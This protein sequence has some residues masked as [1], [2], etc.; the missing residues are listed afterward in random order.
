MQQSNHATIFLLLLTLLSCSRPEPEAAFY[1]WKST[2]E[3][4]ETERQALDTLGA[5]RLYV[6]FFD[7]DVEGGAA[8]P[9]APVRFPEGLPEGLEIVPCV[10]ITNRTFQVGHNPEALADQAWDY[11]QQVNRRYGLAPAEY[12]FD[13]DWSPSNR[14]AYFAFLERIN[15]LKGG[16][17]ASATIRLHQYRYPDQTGVPPVDKG[18]LMYYNMGDIEGV[19]ES[20]SLL[21]NEKGFAYLAETTYPLPLDVALPIFSWALAYRLG[22]L[23]FIINLPGQEA[24]DK[25]P[26][27]EK[28]GGQA[29]KT[30]EN[31]YFE[32]Y[33]LNEGDRLRFE[34]PDREELEAAA[35][36]LRK[37]RSPSGRILFFHLDEPL[38]D[39]YP[40]DFLSRLVGRF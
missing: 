21:N 11:L 39:N 35:G 28:S 38:I 18:T 2:F 4:S 24:L 40:A 6:K 14:Q 15:R 23:A 36:R 25:E 29:Y 34:R 7:L 17:A 1:Y 5:R 10:F 32:G 20:N 26:R 31:F 3:L 16:A 12:Q 37:I 30:T 27:L 9:K 13:C 33:Y 8:A 19:Q 22:S